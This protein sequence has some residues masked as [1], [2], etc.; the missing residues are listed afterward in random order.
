M[1]YF[2]LIVLLAALPVAAQTNHALWCCRFPLRVMGPHAGVDLT[3][4]CQWWVQ[5]GGKNE[6]P[7]I[8]DQDSLTNEVDPQRP[9]ARWKRITGEATSDLGGVWVMRAEIYSSPTSRTN[10]WILLRNPPATEQQQYYDLQAAI[11]QD[12]Q[13]IAT[14]KQ[15]HDADEK[16]A[17]KD[18][19]RAKSID[20]S[21]SKSVRAYGVDYTAME[22]QKK[23]AAATALTNEKQLESALDQAQR[24]FKSL[25]NEEGH[26]KIDIFALEVGRDS[27][28]RLVYDAGQIYV[29]TP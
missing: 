26:Y 12:S 13:Q 29:A 14:D 20:S 21:Y 11:A 8:S 25:P 5:H 4:L 27:K 7:Y 17:E 16:A 19:T 24:V 18:Q 1:K 9:L 28:G 2:Y 22:A 23:S 6:E 10:S 3:P 15:T